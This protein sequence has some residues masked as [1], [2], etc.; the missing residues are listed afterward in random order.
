MTEEEKRALE[1]ERQAAELIKAWACE[2]Y[3]LAII[4]WFWHVAQSEALGI[5]GAGNPSWT[6]ADEELY[7]LVN[8][9][10]PRPKD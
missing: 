2:P 7:Q 3:G 9:N 8:A 5:R 10:K 1:A 6:V 4:R